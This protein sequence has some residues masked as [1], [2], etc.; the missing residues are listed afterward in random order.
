MLLDRL[1][2]RLQHAYIDA[3]G[4]IVHITG[5]IPEE[6]VD[7]HRG[8]RFFSDEGQLYTDWGQTL[9]HPSSLDL[10]REATVAER[11]IH[12]PRQHFVDIGAPYAESPMCVA[13]TDPAFTF[14]VN[15]FYINRMGYMVSREQL[16]RMSHSYH[17]TAN[18]L[19]MQDIAFQIISG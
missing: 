1:V 6:S 17:A 18:I 13:V 7:Y 2:L 4:H 15:G 11:T 5:E 8:Y 14:D 16:V 19:A 9:S 12:K 10:M 3:T